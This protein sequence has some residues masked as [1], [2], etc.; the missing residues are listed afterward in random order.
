MKTTFAARH[1]DPG[2]DLK[3]SSM[4]AITKLQQ[5]YD[6]IIACD[7]VLEPSKDHDNPC[8]A[9]LN[10]KVPQKL[11]NASETGP[12]YELAVNNVVDTAIRQI[13]KYKTKRFEHQ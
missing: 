13:R 10:I 4:E 2:S 11:L 3:D 9:E 1:F 6:R 12:T 5:F 7:I 8:R